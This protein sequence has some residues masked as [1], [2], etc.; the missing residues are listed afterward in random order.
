M[1]S[2]NFPKYDCCLHFFHES[3][4]IT[5]VLTRSSNSAGSRPMTS[6]QASSASRMP[7]L[8]VYHATPPLP[9]QS[10]VP[11]FPSSP[12]QGT[13]SWRLSFRSTPP[14]DRLRP[15]CWSTRISRRLPSPKQPPCSQPSHPRQGKRSDGDWSARTHRCEGM[16]RRSMVP[17]RI[18]EGYSRGRVWKRA[19]RGFS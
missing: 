12:P 7:K 17:G 1:K 14:I 16:R 9:V 13:S 8:S 3:A 18:F 10:S 19:E 6:G 2:I 11:N 4:A 5:N 15:K